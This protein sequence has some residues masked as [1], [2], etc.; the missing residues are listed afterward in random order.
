MDQYYRHFRNGKLYRIIEYATIESTEEEAVVYEAMYDDHRVWI[1]PKSNFFEEVSF[2]GKM[3]PRFQPV[4]HEEIQ[5]ELDQ[6]FNK[7]FEE[8]KALHKQMMD[9][10]RAKYS[11]AEIRVAKNSHR[12][13]SVQ[14]AVE[15]GWIA[16]DM[17]QD[18]KDNIG[19]LDKYYAEEWKSDF[20]AD[21]KGEINKDIDRSI[22]AE[23]TLYN[24]LD[25]IHEL[26]DSLREFVDSIRYPS[27]DEKEEESQ[28]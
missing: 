16:L 6:E 14:D 24:L 12:M 17:L 4:P 28:N 13:K 27:D 23:D 11:D 7:G 22:L 19:L 10:L 2:E 3:V 18:Q 25:E 26:R 15:Q 5:E 9:E 20:E 21:E 8:I 1:R